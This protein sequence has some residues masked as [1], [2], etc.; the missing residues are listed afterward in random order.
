MAAAN[1]KLEDIFRS[2]DKNPNNTPVIGFVLTP[3]TSIHP[4][5]KRLLTVV[6]I[7]LGILSFVMLYL[8]FISVYTSLGLCALAAVL[9]VTW[10]MVAAKLEVDPLWNGTQQQED[11]KK[12]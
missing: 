1:N 5:M 9:L 11:D 3:G 12:K 2:G 10:N 7:A 6:S 4:V 8:D